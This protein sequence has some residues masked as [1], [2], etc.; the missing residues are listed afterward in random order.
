MTPDAWVSSFLQAVGS[1][2]LNPLLYY[3]LAYVVILAAVRIKKE[4]KQFSVKIYDWSIELRMLFLQGVGVGLVLSVFSLLLGI[5]VPSFFAGVLCIGFIVLSLFFRLPLLTPF[6]ILAAS[7]GIGTI[8]Y[9]FFQDMMPKFLQTTAWVEFGFTSL[10]PLL[11]VL[12]L[13]EAFLVGRFGGKDTSPSYKP[14]SRGS[15][16]GIHTAHRLWILPL[17]LLAPVGELSASSWWPILPTYVENFGILLIPIPLGYQMTA[18]GFYPDELAVQYSSRVYGCAILATLGS[19]VT[20]FYPKAGLICFGMVGIL[21]I[22]LT[23]SLR[24]KNQKKNAVFAQQ[25]GGI[26]VLAVLPGTP[27]DAMNIHKGEVIVRVNGEKTETMA[28]LYDVLSRNRVYVKLEVIDRQGEIRH[29]HRSY[30]AGDHHELGIIAIEEERKA[31][32]HI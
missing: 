23:L 8:F 5:M 27:A 11:T 1:F 3:A 24:Y 17:F 20:Y 25:T 2:F 21:Y 30:Y 28:E 6:Y 16:I 26:K 10:L 19:V 4:R 9:Y 13:A 7:M 14:S 29:V 18:K 32:N 22:Y 12:M 31:D 15:R